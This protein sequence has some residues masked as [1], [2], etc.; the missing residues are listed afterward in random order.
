VTAF[1]GR[2]IIYPA[3]L[4][5]GWVAGRVA[6]LNW[7]ASLGLENRTRVAIAQPIRR[8][9]MVK[10]IGATPPLSPTLHGRWPRKRIV[11]S[12]LGQLHLGRPAVT[13]PDGDPQ[14]NPANL[15]LIPAKNLTEATARFAVAADPVRKITPDA[16]RKKWFGYAYSFWR[17]GNNG[18][19][20]VA[21]AGQYGGSQ[22][23]V[24]LGYDLGNS[25][26]EG[27]AI[28]ARAAA[29]PT[30]GGEEFALGLRWQRALALPLSLNAERRIRSGTDD[31]WAVYAA[32]GVDAKPL[33]AGFSLD[34]YGQAGWTSGSAGGGFYDAQVRA[35][36][37][38]VRLGE[39]NINV[40]AGAWAGGQRG[41]G[42]FDVG[43]TIAAKFKI[44]DLPID[45]RLDWR[46]RVAGNARPGDGLALTVSTGF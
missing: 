24:I 46:Q 23:G 3:L 5:S 6:Y 36:R 29:T 13:E 40:G 41:T 2:A 21:P 9:P 44:E 33:P 10:D 7:D 34:A 31:N 18:G 8:V 27:L 35:T 15:E 1:R 20:I 38:I 19:G 25:R 42:R 45:A 14:F 30:K 4:L 43:P 22:S 32:G 37:K 16:P 26:D 28:M 11:V 39:A 17:I 12:R